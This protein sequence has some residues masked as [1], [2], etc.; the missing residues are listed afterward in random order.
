MKTFILRGEQPEQKSHFLPGV[1][2]GDT[3]LSRSE[4]REQI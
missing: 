1:L 3:P 2:R 4:R